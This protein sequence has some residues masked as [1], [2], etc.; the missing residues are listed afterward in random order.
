MLNAKKT[1]WLYPGQG[2][3]YVGMG[4]DL[5]E[6]SPMVAALFEQANDVL[7]TRLTDVMFNGPEEEL[8]QTLNTQ[9]AILATSMALHLL[10]Q[11]KAGVAPPCAVAGHSLG[12]I[13]AFWAA[14][15][16]D[17][18]TA[19]RLVKCRAELMNDAATRIPGR[20]AAVLGLDD[21]VLAEV[22]GA[23]AG[24]VV[25]ANFNAPKQTVISGSI[26]GVDEAVAKCKEAGAKRAIVLPVSGA[27]HS[28]LM[29]QPAGELAK[30]IDGATFNAPVCPVFTN[31]DATAHNDPEVLRANLRRQMTSSVLWTKTIDNSTAQFAPE[32]FV[33]V[34]PGSVLAGLLKRIVPAIPCVGVATWESIVAE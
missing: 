22:V 1:V 30:L 2:S 18:D 3:Q 17:T 4:K 20:M 13:T 14:G 5:V 7:G 16:F 31:C 28:P 33:E 29:Q 12:E 19:L 15:V 21:D 27:F 24:T 9:P 6:N 10:L 34:G 8:R 32:T 26:E 11:A 23:C 25:M